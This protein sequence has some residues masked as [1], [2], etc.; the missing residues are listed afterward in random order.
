M[1]R[2]HRHIGM[3]GD[4]LV[5]AVAGDRVEERLGDELRDASREEF[6]RVRDECEPLEGA[7]GLCVE[8]KRR[9]RVVVLASS[10]NEDDL[11]HF[12]DLLD[13]REVVDGWTTADDV[14]RTKPSPDVI[15]AALAKAG[16]RDA[17]MLGDSRWDV[18]AAARAGLRTVCV[19]TG[20]WS[21]QE[22]LDAGAACVFPSLV[23]LRERLD[24]T[25]LR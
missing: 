25:P 21:E 7:H 3:G 12:L 4:Q 18:E 14:E 6:R 11:D 22:L 1:W 20:G 9:G 8:L 16:T 13:V 10:S 23:E 24:D 15:E 19:I 2:V 5:A 17:A